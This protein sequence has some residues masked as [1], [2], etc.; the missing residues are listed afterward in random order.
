[1]TKR[2][3]ILHPI[4]IG[5]LLTLIINDFYLKP[6]F[7][8]ALTGK[9]SDFS[10]LIVFPIFIAFLFPKT[11]KWISILTGILFII[12]KMPVTTPLIDIFNKTMP[13]KIQRIIDYSDYWAL[14]VLPITHLILNQDRQI[15]INSTKILKLSKLLVATVSFFA[16]CATTVPPAVEVPKGTIYI[17]KKYTIKKSKNEIIEAIK[18]LGYNVNYHKNLDDSTNT[19]RYRTRKIPYYQT[20]N[21]VIYDNNSN[22]IDTILNIKYTMFEPK[23]NKTK[24]E[25]INVTLS[26]DGNIQRWQTLKFLRKQY[27]NLLK[28]QVIRKI[29]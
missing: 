25:I 27:K 21:I 24:I 28:E 10:G 15:K 4:F 1:M 23:E 19:G 29:K 2:N 17:G 7:A 5:C 3:Q 6:V 16:I 13:F 9:L 12:W 26:E 22:P 14:L 18:S 20:D 8:N 11:Q